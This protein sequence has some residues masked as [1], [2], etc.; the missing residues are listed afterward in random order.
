MRLRQ[1][2]L[3]DKV[4]LSG[5]INDLY[6]IIIG[7]LNMTMYSMKVWG[8]GNLKYLWLTLFQYS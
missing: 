3:S 6:L 4:V 5:I 1:K 8:S 2:E 7:Y